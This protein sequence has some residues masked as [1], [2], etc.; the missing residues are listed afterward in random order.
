MD[1]KYTHD[2]LLKIP[3][4]KVVQPYSYTPG[5]KGAY[6]PVNGELNLQNL[7]LGPPGSK[8]TTGYVLPN[9]FNLNV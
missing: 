2:N 6:H 9:I 3:I 1:K 4:T 7:I 5:M 8:K